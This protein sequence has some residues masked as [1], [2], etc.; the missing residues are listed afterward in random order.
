VGQRV[1]DSEIGTLDRSTETILSSRKVMIRELVRCGVLQR[2]TV[3]CSVLQHVEVCCSV[4][5]CVAA[6]CRI[7]NRHS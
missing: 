4:L 6:C 2:F 1:A 3:C 5:Q 7:L